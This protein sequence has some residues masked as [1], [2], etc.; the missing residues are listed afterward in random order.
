MY[1]TTGKGPLLVLVA[2]DDDAMRTL[3]SATLQGEGYA[4]LEARDGAELLDLL[5][6]LADRIEHVS[7]PLA[8][9]PD[10]PLEVHARYTRVEILAAFDI[11]EGARVAPWQTGVYWAADARADLLAFTLDKTTGQFSPTTRYRDYAISPDL[12]HWETQSVTRAESETGRQAKFYSLTTAGRE[13]LEK[14]TANWSRLSAAINLVV[15]E[16]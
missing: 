11:G 16:A 3:V 1:V 7:V 9:H 10:V 6:V 4:T 15:S 13:Q 12:I 2:D 14:E 8:S 5:E